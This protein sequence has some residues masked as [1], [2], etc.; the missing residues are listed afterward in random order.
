M[1]APVVLL[2]SDEAEGLTGEDI[3]AKDLERWLADF[4]SRRGQPPG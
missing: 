4:R 2:A 3:V 1:R